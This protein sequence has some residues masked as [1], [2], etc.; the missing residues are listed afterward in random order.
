[1][2]SN[3]FAVLSIVGGASAACCSDATQLKRIRQSLI[4]RLESEAKAASATVRVG[5][6]A[7]NF[8]DFF[9]AVQETVGWLDQRIELCEP[10]NNVTIPGPSCN[11]TGS[12][13][14][15]L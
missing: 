6:E 4:D 3:S 2:L 9:A 11:Y 14:W 7:W 8:N 15:P 5:D 12:T 10:L 1:M 13:P